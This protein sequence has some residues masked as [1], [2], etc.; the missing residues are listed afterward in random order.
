VVIVIAVVGLIILLTKMVGK[1]QPYESPTFTKDVTLVDLSLTPSQVAFLEGKRPRRVLSLLLIQ[2]L[3]EGSLQITSK[4]PLVLAPGKR[5]SEVK[6]NPFLKLKDGKLDPRIV[7]EYFDH[8]RADMD[9]RGETLDMK[10]TKDYYQKRI[11]HSWSRLKATKGPLEEARTLDQ[12]YG[13]MLSDKVLKKNFARMQK[14]HEELTIPEWL[15][16]FLFKGE[17]YCVKL[18]KPKQ[19]N[20]SFLDTIKDHSASI[21]TTRG[22]TVPTKGLDQMLIESMYIL[23]DGVED[24]DE[25][26]D[27]LDAIKKYKV[28]TPKEASIKDLPRANRGEYVKFGGGM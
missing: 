24:D 21:F 3:R 25:M 7:N 10:S 20:D 22:V 2:S 15:Y 5:S 13:F 16:K 8:L 11:E 6:N 26:L 18:A 12:E 9:E 4:E 14:D 27:L 28:K 23:E 17:K 1:R 19:D